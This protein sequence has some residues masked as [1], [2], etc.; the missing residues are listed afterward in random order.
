MITERRFTKRELQAGEVQF[1]NDV[2]RVNTK[3]DVNDDR[4][5]YSDAYMMFVGDSPCTAFVK[6]GATIGV[7]R[8]ATAGSP[9]MWYDD[10]SGTYEVRCSGGG[11]IY[12]VGTYKPLRDEDKIRCAS[13]VLDW[14]TYKE[15]CH[16]YALVNSISD[17]MSADR[18][19][20]FKSYVDAS[21]VFQIFKAMHAKFMQ[22]TD[23]FNRTGEPADLMSVVNVADVCRA[24]LVF[25]R[26]DGS[27]SLYAFG[28]GYIYNPLGDE[29]G[30]PYMYTDDSSYVVR[31]Y[32]DA[33]AWEMFT[34]SREARTAVDK[35]VLA[36]KARVTD[37]INSVLDN[38][39]NNE[40]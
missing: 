40:R 17:L 20:S 33:K 36:Y 10:F 1:V 28:C 31:V 14:I 27:P 2:I 5:Y 37:K 22:D 26:A 21:R 32:G 15:V 7:A 29:E 6:R 16:V 3:S 35:L 11:K 24:N 18:S 39:K 13:L 23:T 19:H 38:D 25:K 12:T 34:T 30:M 4:R 8:R 9:R